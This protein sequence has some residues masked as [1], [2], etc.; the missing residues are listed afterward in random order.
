MKKGITT[1]R[2]ENA[3]KKSG[4]KKSKQKVMSPPLTGSLLE[5]PG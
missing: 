3:N 1:G 5:L 4:K 2:I